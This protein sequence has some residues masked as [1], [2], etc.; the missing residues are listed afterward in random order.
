LRIF[1]Q[2]SSLLRLNSG[3]REVAMAEPAD[4]KDSREARAT[5]ESESTMAQVG[6]YSGLGLQW[7]LSVGL[8]MAGGRWLDKR[9]G[10]DPYLTV[11]GAF[12]GGA[13]GFYS[14]YAALMKGQKDKAPK[15]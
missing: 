8:F 7:A 9:I 2:A 3:T 11:L 4:G 10:T 1:S 14:M 13:A 15:A 12:V 6:R 5:P